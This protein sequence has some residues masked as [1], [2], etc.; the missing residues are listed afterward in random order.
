MPPLKKTIWRFLTKPKIKLL[1]DLIIQLLGIYLEKSIIQ[2]NTCTL[3]FTVALFLIAKT[4]KQPK[5]PL[6]KEWIKKMW[7]LYTI[8]YYLATKRRC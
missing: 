4:R 5:H 3:I 7:Y 6:T 1:Y 8:E 2:K